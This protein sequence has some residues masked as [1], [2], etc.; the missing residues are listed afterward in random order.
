MQDEEA[1]LEDKVQFCLWTER[2]FVR[3]VCRRHCPEATYCNSS[4]WR[5]C[6]AVTKSLSQP[7]SLVVSLCNP[8]Q[9]QSQNC[10]AKRHQVPYDGEIID[11]VADG[12]QQA[13]SV[14]QLFGP[15]CHGQCG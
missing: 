10:T 5:L 8:S 11:D 4:P 7:Q 12:V 9:S 6:G 1:Y 3:R 15:L 2:G 14:E 13:I